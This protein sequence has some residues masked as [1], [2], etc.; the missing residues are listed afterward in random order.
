LWGK[1]EAGRPHTLD[2]LLIV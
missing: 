2:P 1:N